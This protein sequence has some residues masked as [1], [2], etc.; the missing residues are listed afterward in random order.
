LS[1][2]VPGV[3]KQTANGFKTTQGAF[4]QKKNIS[5][6]LFFHLFPPLFFGGGG[7]GGA[8]VIFIGFFK[9]KIHPPESE[10]I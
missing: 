8:G 9:L 2:T 7:G 1:I 10:K 4:M 6:A 3:S 5:A